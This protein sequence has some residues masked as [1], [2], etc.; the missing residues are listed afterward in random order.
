MTIRKI[1]ADHTGPLTIDASLLGH[2]GRI[3][4]RAEADC[5]RALVTI[6]TAEEEGAAADLVRAARLHQSADRLSITANGEDSPIT[7]SHHTITVIKRSGAVYGITASGDVWVNGAR[8]TAGAVAAGGA[9]PIEITAVVP[10]GSKVIASTQSA[11][12]AT[13]GPLAEVWARTQSGDLRV[14]EA[15]EVTA[16]TQSGDADLGRTGTADVR[17]MSGDIRIRN[18][19]ENTRLKTMSG[20]IRVQAASAGDI[21]ARTMSGDIDITASPAALAAGLNIEAR[22]MSGRIDTPRNRR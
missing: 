21:N 12:I 13:T 4:V 19:G 2:G 6:S 17:T 16:S 15:E 5:V 9:A 22:S 3:T 7:R 11:G 1:T 20:D 18:T 14:D 8:V 10:P